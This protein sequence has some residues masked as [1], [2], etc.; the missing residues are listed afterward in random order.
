METKND[1]VAKIDFLDLLDILTN[2]VEEEDNQLFQQ[3]RLIYLDDNNENSN[4]Q[5]AMHV[6]DSRVDV[7]KVLIEEVHSESF[8]INTID[9]FQ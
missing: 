5:I 1:K 7:E 2:H 6:C 8:S 9:S 3:V 4:P